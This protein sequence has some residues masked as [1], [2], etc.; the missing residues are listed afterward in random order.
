M[1]LVDFQNLL[2]MRKHENIQLSFDLVKLDLSVLAV[3]NEVALM[4]CD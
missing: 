3:K 2:C 4:H 1:F